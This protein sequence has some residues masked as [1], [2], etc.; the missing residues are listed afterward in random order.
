MGLNYTSL[1]ISERK[2]KN[3]KSCFMKDFEHKV[4]R[5]NLGP[6][7]MNVAGLLC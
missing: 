5:D 6:G 1:S 4:F 7:L 3:L 2:E